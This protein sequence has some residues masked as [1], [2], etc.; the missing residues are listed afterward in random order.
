MARSAWGTALQQVIV[1]CT[2]VQRRGGLAAFHFPLLA[3][4]Y[5]AMY[6]W[7]SHHG[8]ELKRKMSVGGIA[9]GEQDHSA[10]MMD[11]DGDM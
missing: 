7:R 3:K 10:D 2:I 4:A 9:H 6:P 5:R 11:A 8:L 1:Q